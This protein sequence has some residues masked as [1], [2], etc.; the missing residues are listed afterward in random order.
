MLE[1]LNNDLKKRGGSRM[2]MFKVEI[3]AGDSMLVD[4]NNE[5]LLLVFTT[6]IIRLVDLFH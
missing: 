3:Y 6:L 1:A 2:Q 5:L 4:L